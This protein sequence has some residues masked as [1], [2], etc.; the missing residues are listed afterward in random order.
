MTADL[1]LAGETYD[2]LLLDLGLPRMDGLELLKRS[3]N[4]EVLCP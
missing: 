4:V 1:A 3:G 2:A